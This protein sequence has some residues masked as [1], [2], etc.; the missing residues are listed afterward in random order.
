MASELNAEQL[1]DSAQA[2]TGL[3]DFGGDSFHQGL[4]VLIADVNADTERPEV[5]EAKA[6]LAPR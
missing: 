3:G 2:A 6:F 1:I 5:R 4:E